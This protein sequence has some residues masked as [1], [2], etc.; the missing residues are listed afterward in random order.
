MVAPNHNP[1]ARGGGA[2]G[3]S[4]GPRTE[5]GK[6]RSSM[7]AL[8][9]GLTAQT[10]LLP[11]E[12]PDELRE[13]G[14]S[15]EAE[16]RP[17]GPLQRML[18]QRVVAI[19][20][21]LR[22]SA[23]AEETAALKMEEERLAWWHHRGRMASEL[24][25][26]T[27]R[28][29]RPQPRDAGA[30]LADS[31]LERSGG[32][33]AGDGRLLRITAYEL[34]LEGSLRATMRELRVLQKDENFAPREPEPRPSLSEPVPATAP[35]P[36]SNAEPVP[37]SQVPGAPTAPPEKPPQLAAVEP[38]AEPAPDAE[39][40]AIREERRQGQNELGANGQPT[41]SPENESAGP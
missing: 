35:T 33:D 26:A 38:A 41:A 34:K 4:T 1:A 3:R 20:W 6:A 36:S 25:F 19:A 40:G 24:P 13:F 29:P 2:A 8:K 15:L 22:R 10:S 28:G 30:L 12:D 23:A 37:V 7:N 27:R 9:H 14:E 11:G 17:M 16:L 32:G 5:A 18:V 31:F 39:T 21:K